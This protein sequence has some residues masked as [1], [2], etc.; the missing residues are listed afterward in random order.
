MKI[1][2]ID[3]NNI[4]LFLSDNRYSLSSD[5]EELE[6][7]FR[8]IFEHLKE[9]YDIE[10]EGYYL[11]DIYID[12]YYGIVVEIEKDDLEYFEYLE[13]QVDMRISI[14]NNTL[15]L[16]QIYDCLDIPSMLYKKID[17]YVYKNK[18]YGKVKKSLTELESSILFENTLSIQ[19]DSLV[20]RIVQQNNL[21]KN[22]ILF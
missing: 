19:Y 15:I 3:M 1:I 10:V 14:H 4:V 16:Y 7:Q 22:P 5:M 2:S 13:S 20:K 11:I 8:K 12:E 18:I 21:I 17:F 6:V 9:L